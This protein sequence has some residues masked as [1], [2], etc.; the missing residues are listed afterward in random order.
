MIKALQLY[1]N[2]PLH[3]LLTGSLVLITSLR[4]CLLK[5]NQDHFLG[6]KTV[7]VT[8]GSPLV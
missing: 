3:L 4:K 6:L 8:L 5:V 7:A 1:Y 2:M